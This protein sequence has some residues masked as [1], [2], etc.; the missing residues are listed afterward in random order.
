MFPGLSAQLNIHRTSNAV[1]DHTPGVH[2]CVYDNASTGLEVVGLAPLVTGV[3]NIEERR[4]GNLCRR[5]SRTW[6]SV[7]S[8]RVGRHS[9]IVEETH[10][11]G[12]L[13][14]SAPA[15]MRSV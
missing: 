1:I 4:R 15:T 11:G 10:A 5:V 12:A 7:R 13:R 6:S 3:E 8:H 14:R 2:P 9:R